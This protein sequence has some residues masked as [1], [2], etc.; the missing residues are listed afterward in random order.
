MGSFTPCWPPATSDK[1]EKWQVR[2]GGRP[3][4][5]LIWF[6]GLVIA[7]GGFLAFLGRLRIRFRR[8]PEE[9][10]WKQA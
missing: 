7:F 4:V 3:L 5:T 9:N 8:K 10:V 1:R 6:G 2:C